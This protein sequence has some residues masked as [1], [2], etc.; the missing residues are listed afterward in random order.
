M[1]RID[2]FVTLLLASAG[3]RWIVNPGHRQ[4]VAVLMYH[5]ISD[6][7]QDGVHPYFKVNTTPEIFAEHLAFLRSHG[8]H[9]MELHQLVSC[10]KNCSPFPDKSVIITFDDG[11]RDFYTQAFPLLQKYGMQA[12]MF[13]PTAFI[14]SSAKTYSIDHSGQKYLTW[15]EVRH[16]H[17]AGMVF[18]SHTVNHYKLV[19]LD[20][21]SIEQEL[22]QSRK[23]IEDA[24][25]CR[26]DTFSYPY[27]FP[28][29]DKSFV[30][31]LVDCL[32]RSG[33]HCGVSTRI[34]TVSHGDSIYYM[35]RIPVNCCDDIRFFQAKVEGYYN[36]LH[37]VQYFSKVLR[38]IRS[39][40]R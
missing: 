15:D 3:L 38:N 29:H 23:T 39:R 11:L 30:A 33:Y 19:T 18:G 21:K 26:I 13:L 36:W 37:T 25:G 35:R 6:E 5:G 2:R 28:E 32:Q 12:V 8:Y 20:K 27:K 40:R 31:G 34:G 1:I 16:M 14:G 7:A 4:S 9:T 10:L 22:V 17:Q 24:L